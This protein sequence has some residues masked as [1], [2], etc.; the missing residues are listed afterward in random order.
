MLKSVLLP[1]A[2]FFISSTVFYFFF[3]FSSSSSSSSSSSFSSI[4]RL[5]EASNNKVVQWGEEIGGLASLNLELNCRTPISQQKI[6]CSALQPNPFLPKT[7]PVEDSCEI[8]KH[9]VSSNYE[10]QQIEKANFLAKNKNFSNRKKDLLDFV[11]SDSQQKSAVSFLDRIRVRSA[12]DGNSVN[13]TVEDVSFLSK[14][15]VRKICS[16][17]EVEA[18]TFNFLPFLILFMIIT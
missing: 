2:F 6:C 12:V 10:L 9:Y 16:G 13:Q 1:I 3:P 17:V 4:R 5:R 11:L 15:R 7:F 14:F 18:C 8:V